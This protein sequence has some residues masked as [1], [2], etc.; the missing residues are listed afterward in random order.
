MNSI[1][2]TAHKLTVFEIL[3]DFFISMYSASTLSLHIESTYSMI[4]SKSFELPAS[5]KQSACL[6]SSETLLLYP[7][8]LSNCCVFTSICVQK[9]WVTMW[10]D[11]VR[12]ECH[13]PQSE[14]GVVKTNPMLT[15]YR[16]ARIKHQT[17]MQ[18][19]QASPSTNPLAKLL[20]SKQWP[21]LCREDWP[22]PEGRVTRPEQQVLKL[23]Y[24]LM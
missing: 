14:L 4:V 1:V 17:V 22:L 10:S 16:N 3:R 11:V 12:H 8:C 15:E 2:M 7:L 6:A 20:G 18:K 21:E 13:W 23:F 24:L 9:E 19:G 5:C